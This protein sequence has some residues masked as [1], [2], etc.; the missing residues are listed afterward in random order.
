MTFRNCF[1]NVCV[2]VTLVPHGVGEFGK[3][4]QQFSLEADLCQTEAPEQALSSQ[5]VLPVLTGTTSVS[6]NNLAQCLLHFRS[7]S[8]S[9]TYQ[10]KLNNRPIV[11]GD[12]FIINLMFY[13]FKDIVGEGDYI[14]IVFVFRSH[15]LH[16]RTNDSFV[17]A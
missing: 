4:W 8:T 6:L 1:V 5:A 9:Y 10:K 15:Q 7:S 12:P 16:S 11:F 17:F 3:V 14:N 2:C 13:I